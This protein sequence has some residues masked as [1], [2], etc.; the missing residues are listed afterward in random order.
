MGFLPIQILI[1][2]MLRNNADV[3]RCSY[4]ELGVPVVTSKFILTGE[5]VSR[6]KRSSIRCMRNRILMSANSKYHYFY[7][8]FY[9]MNKGDLTLMYF[10]VFWCEFID[11]VGFLGCC[12]TPVTLFIILKQLSVSTVACNATLTPLHNTLVT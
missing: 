10:C 7:F 1:F 9:K 12:V 6:Y 11:L 3:R 2:R 4:F 5:S 8:F